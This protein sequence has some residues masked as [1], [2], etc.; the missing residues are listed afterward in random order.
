M[1]S[2]GD[3][4]SFARSGIA[5]ADLMACS[6]IASSNLEIEMKCHLEGFPREGWR[7]PIIFGQ[8]FPKLHESQNN[9][10]GGGGGTG[11]LRSHL[12]CANVKGHILHNT[13]FS[14]SSVWR[15]DRFADSR[16]TCLFVFSRLWTTPQR[17]RTTPRNLHVQFRFLG[18]DGTDRRAVQQSHQLLDP[19][20]LS[21]CATRPS[22]F[23]HVCNCLSS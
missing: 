3:F 5:P 8:I 19:A 21:H 2:W 17:Q 10:G 22:E 7:Q 14:N 1:F 9:L 18:H 6:K 15:K 11:H 20:M 4:N 16:V 23:R 13:L 12:G